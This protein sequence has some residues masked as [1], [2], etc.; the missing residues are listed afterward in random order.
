MGREDGEGYTS[1]TAMIGAEA[2]SQVMNDSTMFGSLPTT[3]LRN[4]EKKAEKKVL[5]IEDAPAGVRA[6][7][8]AGCT[9]LGLAT[10]HEIGSLVEAGADWI[11]KDLEGVSV[12]NAAEG[13]K[14]DVEIMGVWSGD[15]PS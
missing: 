3:E 9:V 2:A 13:G 5:V 14:F 12:R 1:S 6:A 10:T 11:V 7:K 15:G 4:Q 8:A